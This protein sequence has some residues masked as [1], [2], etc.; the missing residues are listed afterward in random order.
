MPN[1]NQ[2]PITLQIVHRNNHLIVVY[3]LNCDQGGG[4]FF[5]ISLILIYNTLYILMAFLHCG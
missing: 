4:Y 3:T 2:N 5:H 1:L